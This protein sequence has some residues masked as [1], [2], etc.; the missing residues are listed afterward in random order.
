[1]CTWPDLGLCRS[2]RHP[3]FGALPFWRLHRR[4]LLICYFQKSMFQPLCLTG[5]RH[6]SRDDKAGGMHSNKLPIQRVP[7][8]KNGRSGRTC[9]L[10]K[11]NDTN[12]DVLGG[13][14]NV[15]VQALSNPFFQLPAGVEKVS[16]VPR[17]VLPKKLPSTVPL[18]AQ[19]H[20]SSRETL[21]ELSNLR[22]ILHCRC[23]VR[24]S[25]ERS[26]D[27]PHRASHATADLA[28]QASL[29]PDIVGSSR[30]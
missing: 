19:F 24:K 2:T 25:R 23:S 15:R 18:L 13:R 26:V 14:C 20:L 7:T 16:N 21:L 10:L 4:C 8:A 17:S 3:L 30:D 11:T 22:S 28:L 6:W 5:M 9:S 1:V 12:N 29:L 27:S